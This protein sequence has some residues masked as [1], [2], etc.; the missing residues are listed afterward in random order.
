MWIYRIC[1]LLGRYLRARGMLASAPWF[2]WRESWDGPNWKSAGHTSERSSWRSGGTSTTMSWSSWNM[3]GK[4]RLQFGPPLRLSKHS[5]LPSPAQIRRR[6]LV[7]KTLGWLIPLLVSA[8]VVVV[9]AVVVG[10]FRIVAAE[11]L[12]ADVRVTGW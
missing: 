9:A 2:Y 3:P 1:R 11:P 10:D 12:Q 8:L 5:A 6:N 7:W 4:E